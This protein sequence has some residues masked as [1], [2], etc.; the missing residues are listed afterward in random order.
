MAVSKAK[1]ADLLLHWSIR[2]W[3]CRQCLSIKVLYYKKFRKD[4]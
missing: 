1:A 4:C 3:L 2:L